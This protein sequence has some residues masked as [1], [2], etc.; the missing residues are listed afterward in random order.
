LE[1][2]QVTSPELLQR[3]SC[4]ASSTIAARRAFS[5]TFG[6]VDGDHPAAPPEAAKLISRAFAPRRG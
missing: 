2:L 4:S 6:L 1:R 5:L 3:R